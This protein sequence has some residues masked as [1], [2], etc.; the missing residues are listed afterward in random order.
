MRHTLFLVLCC[1]QQHA[2]IMS[3][4][5]VNRGPTKRARISRASR[6]RG[7][8]FNFI[9][10]NRDD[11]NSAIPI[12]P[13]AKDRVNDPLFYFREWPG[14]SIPSDISQ[15]DLQFIKSDETPSSKAKEGFVEME[16]NYLYH[17]YNSYGYVEG[18]SEGDLMKRYLWD[19][20]FGNKKIPVSDSICWTTQSIM[21]GTAAKPHATPTS[22]GKAIETEPDGSDSGK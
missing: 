19:D 13:A 10:R 5:K 11:P 6:G 21:G 9:R 1:L 17:A 18:T 16:S 14:G 3:Q 8:T 22:A 12:D 4:L 15:E 7:I 20:P 2:R